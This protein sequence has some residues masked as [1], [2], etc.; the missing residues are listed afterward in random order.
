[1]IGKLEAFAER[2]Q[3]GLIEAMQAATRPEL[4]DESGKPLAESAVRA[5]AEAIDIFSFDISA[6]TVWQIAAE[7]LRRTKYDDWLKDRYEEKGEYEARNRNVGE[8]L[9]SIADYCA[10]EP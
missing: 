6:M 9:N 2:R 7:L 3:V 10:K 8:L 5:C 4:R 1:M